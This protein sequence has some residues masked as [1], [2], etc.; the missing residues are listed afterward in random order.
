MGRERGGIGGGD[1]ERG[2]GK[3]EGEGKRRGESRGRSKRGQEVR[4]REGD[5]QVTMTTKL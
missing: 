1:R 2:E 4:G 3:K 5:K